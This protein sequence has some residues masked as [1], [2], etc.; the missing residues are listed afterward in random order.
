[1]RE[2]DM[3]QPLFQAATQYDFDTFSVLF[4]EMET[5]PGGVPPEALLMRAQIKLYAADATFMADLDKVGAVACTPAYPCMGNLWKPDSSNRFIVF[6]RD[7]QA[8]RQFVDALPMA[9]EKLSRFY[10]DVGGGMARQMLSEICYFIGDFERAL[11]IAQRQ[12]N[13]CENDAPGRVLALYVMFRCHLV[14]GD[15]AGAGEDMLE[16]I[17]LSQKYPECLPAYEV[18]RAWANLTTG[19]SGDTPRFETDADGQPLPVFAD[20]VDSIYDGIAKL[21]TAEAHFAGYASAGYSNTCTMRQHYMDI[22]HTLYWFEVGDNDKAMAYFDKA[23]AV[24]S[25]C[26][27]LTPFAEYGRQIFSLLDYLQNTATAAQDKWITDVRGIAKQYEKGIDAYR[28]M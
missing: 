24:S 23:Y 4:S 28:D 3:L 27:L 16:M 21:S 22:F 25:A 9:E 14:G 18:I 10:G 7:P 8:F 6:N 12:Y 15:A 2:H 20:R 19:W 5:R 1:M 26:G 17:S 11:A 13:K